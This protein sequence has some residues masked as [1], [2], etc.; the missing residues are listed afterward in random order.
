[1]LAMIEMERARCGQYMTGISRKRLS[2][3]RPF[4][5]GLLQS[6]TI[7]TLALIINQ[8]FDLD[9]ILTS[10]R[11]WPPQVSDARIFDVHRSDLVIHR[12]FIY[13]ESIMPQT[14][15]SQVQPVK[16]RCRFEMTA[17]DAPSSHEFCVF[18]FPGCEGCPKA[19]HTVRT[20]GSSEDPMKSEALRAWV[21]GAFR[22]NQGGQLWRSTFT[23]R[24]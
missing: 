4:G 8:K 6:M 14:Q 18:E 16:L 7:L 21:A 2:G 13:G 24:T 23:A 1:M 3:Q 11:L 17:A 10:D 15:R 19:Q 20:V 22:S 9:Q 12:R 5:G